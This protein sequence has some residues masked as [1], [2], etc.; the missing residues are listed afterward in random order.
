MQLVHFLILIGVLIFVHE[1]GH[2]FFAKLFNVR[3]ERFAIG[4]G[5]AVPAL[6]FRRGETMY[7]ICLLPIGGYVK[8]FGMQ[9]EHH[10]TTRMLGQG[11]GLPFLV[12]YP[13]GSRRSPDPPPSLE[14]TPV[15][16]AFQT[17]DIDAAYAWPS[18]AARTANAYRAVIAGRRG[19][20]PA[21]RSAQR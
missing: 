17:P 11:A 16:L 18:V 8:M 15:W 3:V 6:S 1:F 20:R 14:N 19:R 7:A 13:G 21:S 9:P 2:Y 4:M 12:F 5:P 10:G